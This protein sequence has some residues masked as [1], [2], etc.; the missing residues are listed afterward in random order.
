MTLTFLLAA[1]VLTTAACGE[2]ESAGQLGKTPEE[3]EGLPGDVRVLAER[4]ADFRGRITYDFDASVEGEEGGGTMTVYSD[5]PNLRRS[6]DSELGGSVTI[7]STADG[8]FLCSAGD[9]SS[10]GG[11]CFEYSFNGESDLP[12]VDDMFPNPMQIAGSFVGLGSDGLATEEAEIAG[13]PA[14]CT[15]T[16]EGVDQ[17]TLRVCFNPE[18]AVVLFSILGPSGE[19]LTMEASDI[20]NDVSE[21]DFALP[22]DVTAPEDLFGSSE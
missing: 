18:G 3:S 9:A 19:G 4:S 5:P 15:S 8:T 14:L 1:F 16:S 2:G 10:S 22:Y 21:S 12:G 13:E 7:I 20:S 6:I 17:G 11:S